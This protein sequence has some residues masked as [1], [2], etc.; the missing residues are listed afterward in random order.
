MSYD[1]KGSTYDMSIKADKQEIDGLIAYLNAAA[2]TFKRL[3]ETVVNCCIEQYAPNS[4]IVK[5]LKV[6]YLSPFCQ[7]KWEVQ[8]APVGGKVKWHIL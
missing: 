1:I 3:I 5:M 6:L 4:V 7:G 2:P 8:L